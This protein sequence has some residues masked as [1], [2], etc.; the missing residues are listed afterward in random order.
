MIPPVQRP[1]A[2]AL[3]GSPVSLGGSGDRVVRVE[4]GCRRNCPGYV[5]G[6]HLRQHGKQGDRGDGNPRGAG[7]DAQ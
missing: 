7:N 2:L 6:S 5:R 4:S 3:M 1:E